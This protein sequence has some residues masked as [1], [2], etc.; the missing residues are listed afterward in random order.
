[1]Q[2]KREK[3]TLSQVIEILTEFAHEPSRK[4]AERYGVSRTCITDL[5]RGWT[6]KTQLHM[7]QQTEK[8]PKSVWQEDRPPLKKYKK[9]TQL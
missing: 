9:E 3:L 4:V 2:S 8:L 5:R 7:L 1:M 6:W